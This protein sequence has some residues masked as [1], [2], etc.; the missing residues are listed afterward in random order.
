MTKTFSMVS[1]K[2][3]NLSVNEGFVIFL[4]PVN[5]ML[6]WRFHFEKESQV[7]CLFTQ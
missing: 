6:Y 4:L 1:H 7:N 3:Y 5:Y 2:N